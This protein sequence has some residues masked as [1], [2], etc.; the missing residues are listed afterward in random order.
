MV[1][2]TKPADKT[3]TA[4][5]WPVIDKWPP[6]YG[7]DQVIY[8]PKA[9]GL[10]AAGRAVQRAKIMHVL[11][12][13]WVK[14]S[15]RIVSFDEIAYLQ[16]ELRMGSTL[17]TYYREAR[18]LGITIVASTQRPQGITRWM[19]SESSWTVCFRPKDDDDSER[20]AQVLGNKRF[21]RDILTGL[22]RERHEFLMLRTLTGESYISALP[23]RAA[24]R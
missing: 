9:S 17:T 6:S 2:A 8:W 23:F 7:Q 4:L 21:Y 12:K 20:V 24:R 14:D 22:D 5:G 15:N 3:L 19:H 16:H 11:T 10:T 1:I 13:L 18:A